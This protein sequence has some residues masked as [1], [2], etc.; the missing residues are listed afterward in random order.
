[1]L[2]R[3]RMGG[4]AFIAAL[5]L[6][7]SGCGL[8]G[9]EEIA[10]TPQ[11]IDPPPLTEV[12]KTGERDLTQGE[13]A[14]TTDG[15]KEETGAATYKT[16]IYVQDANGYVVPFTVNVRKTEGQAKEVLRYLVKGGP[17]ESLL[18]DGFSAVLP[19]GTKILGM[20]VKD[21]AATVDFSPE[22]KNYDAKDEQRIVDAITWTLTEFA[23]IDSV[24]IW[25]NG[26]PQDVMPVNGTPISSLSRENGINLELASNVKIGQTS[27][28]TLYFQGQTEGG[29]TY[30]VPVTRLVDEKLDTAQAAIEQL[31]KGPRQ[32]TNL[33]SALLPSTKLIHIKQEGDTVVANFDETILKFDSGK[34]SPDA[35]QSIVLSL[36]ESTGAKKVQ[37]LVNGKGNVVADGI[38][39]SKPVTRPV[40]INPVNL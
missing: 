4:F 37:I 36:T 5:M 29:F 12:D 10:T 21:G 14:E 24:K 31:I 13:E 20:V 27:P 17:V 9:P 16:T 11:T 6:L 22:F 25:I 2:T 38:D 34:A 18:P 1:M 8:F 23:S 32:G 19:E 15:D 26:Y 35:M 30:F 39:Y 3:R 7:L 40:D 33:F 28:V